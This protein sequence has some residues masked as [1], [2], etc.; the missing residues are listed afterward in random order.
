M[1]RWRF[2]AAFAWPNWAN[3]TAY[4]SRA[5]SASPRIGT[6]LTGGKGLTADGAV[7]LFLD[8]QEVLEEVA[9]RDDQTTAGSQLVHERLR[10]MI[11]CGGHDNDVERR[12]LGPS[13]VPV[14]DTDRDVLV[15]QGRQSV[16][17][18]RRPAA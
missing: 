15:A 13:S 6:N 12:L 3:I 8:H 17:A 11:R 2:F 4:L 16:S 18:R 14:A 7:L 9:H 1:G 10:H 5:V